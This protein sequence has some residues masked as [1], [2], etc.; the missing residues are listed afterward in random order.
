MRPFMTTVV[1]PVVRSFKKKYSAEAAKWVKRGGHAIVFETPK[2]AWLVFRAP[3]A[4][5]PEGVEDLGEWAVLDL[6]KQRWQVPERGPFRAL[7]TTLVPPQHVD[8]VERWIERDSKWP[9][10]TRKIS[11]DCLKCG[12]CCRDNEVT[13]LKQDIVRFRKAGRMDLL[14]PP[15]ARR[16]DG[17]LVLTLLKSKDCRHLARDNKCGIYAVRPDA[18]STFPVGSECCLFARE[19]EMGI[20]DGLPPHG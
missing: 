4:N 7:A 2:R 16:T 10:P 17:K 18:C 9:G 14:K 11:F 3:D 15:F 1:R 8:V 19:D 12:S 6:G 20:Y 13:I 5:A